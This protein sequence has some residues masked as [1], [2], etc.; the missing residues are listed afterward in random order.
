M[1]AAGEMCGE[2]P[3]QQFGVRPRDY[4]VHLFS[5]KAVHKQIPFRD[6]LYFI[7]EQVVEITVDFIQHFQHIVKVISLKMYETFIVKIDI[8]ELHTASH[9]SIIT[10][11]RF[12]A[13]SHAD[14]NLSLSAVEINAVF[15]FSLAESDG[16][17]ECQF[18]HLICEYSFKYSFIHNQFFRG[19]GTKLN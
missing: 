6:I 12:A 2:F 9:K 14:H 8:G 4:D 17:F 10:E 11:G 3:A 13:A 15:L 18:L 7:N 16:L 1:M 5:Q 19:K